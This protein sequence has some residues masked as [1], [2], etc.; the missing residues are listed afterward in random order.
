MKGKDRY[1]TF[2]CPLFVAGHFMR[3]YN[4]MNTITNHDRLFAV[5]L[6]SYTILSC[7]D[8]PATK[9]SLISAYF[10]QPAFALPI[11]PWLFRRRGQQTSA[12]ERMPAYIDRNTL[13]VY[14]IHYFFIAAIHLE[15][16]SNYFY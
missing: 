14:V 5:C 1:A 13:D 2:L 15:A 8:L 16:A 10:I 9:L 7:T 6:I 3:K 12:T 4:R 11:I